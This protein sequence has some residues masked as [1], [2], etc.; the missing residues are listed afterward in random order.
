[1]KKNGFI[2]ISVIYSFFLVFLM[3]LLFIINNLVNNRVLLNNVKEQVKNDISDSNFSRYLINHSD[4]LG[5]FKHDGSISTDAND[6]SYRYIGSNPNNYV[7]FDSICNVED[8]YRIIGVI[9]GKVKVIKYKS[10]E[11]VVY[12]NNQNSVYVNSNMYSYLQSYVSS[13]SIIDKLEVNKFYVGGIEEK[14]LN[15][16]VYTIYNY[17]VGSNRN[18]GVT[19]DDI[20]GLPYISDYAYAG[21]EYG[22]VVSGTNNWMNNSEEMWVFTRESVKYN[23]MYYINS[24][25]NLGLD[26]VDKSKAVRPVFVLKNS[27]MIL[28]GDGTSDNPYIIS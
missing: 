26:T 10:I 1:M 19:I 13:L 11:N 8:M 23:Y 12:D 4:E 15:E 27:V 5:L 21:E 6:N 14:F 20:I 3:L 28:G 24:S 2:S 25:G 22:D 7:C 17:E 16:K 18:N 9:N